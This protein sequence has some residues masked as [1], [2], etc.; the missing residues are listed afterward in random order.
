[1]SKL[2]IG[3]ALLLPGALLVIT[4]SSSALA[5]S[6]RGFNSNVPG[7]PVGD[8][9]ATINTDK[10]DD[11]TPLPSCGG[12][13]VNG[14]MI[15]TYK[16]VWSGQNWAK[17]PP[18]IKTVNTAVLP[19]LGVSR[20]DFVPQSTL[21]DLPQGALNGRPVYLFQRNWVSL[22][23]APQGGG[24]TATLVASGGGNLVASGGGNIVN[25]NSGNILLNGGANLARY[26]L[27]M[28]LR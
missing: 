3:A 20:G 18:S 28:G 25:T 21:S 1:M 24:Y 12:R 17:Y 23:S 10:F 2:S 14:T 15:T 16:L 22:A 9:T 5:I 19:N 4:I 11:G 13:K 27:A 7:C 26:K 8:V 6:K